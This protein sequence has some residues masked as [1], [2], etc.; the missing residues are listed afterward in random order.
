MA[1]MVTRKTIRPR[2]TG[3]TRSSARSEKELRRSSGSSSRVSCCDQ[4]R[5]YWSYR[6][7]KRM[8]TN[9]L[10]ERVSRGEAAAVAR[11]ISKIEDGAD[12][13]AELMKEIYQR[14]GSSLV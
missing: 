2:N 7:I 11:A 9:N 8:V 3:A 4:Y 6:P 14:T 12:G 13:A 1:G 10:S 5:S